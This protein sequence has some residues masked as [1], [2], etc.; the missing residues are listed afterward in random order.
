MNIQKNSSLDIHKAIINKNIKKIKNL[1]EN[2][3]SPNKQTGNYNTPL[4]IAVLKGNLSITKL[5]QKYHAN[6]NLKNTHGSTPLH[7]ALDK[8]NNFP[9]IKQLLKMGTNPNYSDRYGNTPL[10]IALR[11]HRDI[12]VIQ[13]LLKAGAN[14]NAVNNDLETPLAIAKKLKNDSYIKILHLHKAKLHNSNIFKLLKIT[15]H[16]M[17]KLKKLIFISFSSTIIAAAIILSTLISE[18]C[19]TGILFALL[20]SLAL[21]LIFLGEQYY[22]I[23]KTKK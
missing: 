16:T 5:L 17:P 1:L 22:K 23:Q 12:K 15:F 21:A 8:K 9:I 7:I 10:H 4:H 2:N 20:T 18:I 14:P 13:A 6:P 19:F 3:V 11:N